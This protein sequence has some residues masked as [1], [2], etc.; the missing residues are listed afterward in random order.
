MTDSTSYEIILSYMPL[1]V[2]NAMYR[3]SEKDR[4]A[5]EIRL[6]CGRAVSYI[7]PDRIKYLTRNGQLTESFR[8]PETV[9]V[10]SDDVKQTVEKLCHFS[11]HSCTKEL[12]EGYFVLRN[13]IRVGV[14]GTY[15]DTTGKTIGN[16]NALNFRIA[17]CIEGCSAEIYSRVSGKS[18]LICG[19]VNSG[20]TT[21][22]RDLCR[23]SGNSFK[24]TLIDER[25]E[26]SSMSGGLPENDVGILTDVLVNCGRAYG[27][28][29]AVRT[30]SPD[31]IFCDEISTPED[32]M[33]ILQAFGCG[34]RFSATVHA[35]NYENLLRRQAIRPLLESG[36]FEYAVF[37]EK[38][39]KV[40]EIRRL[41]K[42]F[43][44]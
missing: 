21:V 4:T 10:T 30:L 22:L 43:S 37:L 24:V 5:T 2:R 28:I 31:M 23:L 26:I 16:F 3:V 9:T 19:G 13:G 39:G 18:V 14:A 41:G 8:N 12:H 29:S 33:A 7:F 38:L 15:S 11:V 32:S 34:V 17:R 6:R 25:N 44:E 20:K 1:T 42:C 36:V 40:R 27:I 35:E